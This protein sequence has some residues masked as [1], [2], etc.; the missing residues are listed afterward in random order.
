MTKKTIKYMAGLLAMALW[1]TPATAQQQAEKAK[2]EVE[3]ARISFIQMTNLRPLGDEFDSVDYIMWSKDGKSLLVDRRYADKRTDALEINVDTQAIK[4][5]S[6]GRPNGLRCNNGAPAWNPTENGYIFVG[7]SESSKDFSRSIPSNGQQC[8]LWYYNAGTGKYTALTSYQLSFTSPRGV[9]MPRFSPDGKKVFFEPYSVL[10]R[11]EDSF[12]DMIRDYLHMVMHCIFRHPYDE[13]HRDHRSWWLACDV[14]AESVAME[15]CGG[16]FDCEDDKA[17]KAALSELRLLC[18][19]IMPGKLYSLFEKTYKAPYGKSHMGLT[20]EKLNEY[21]SLFERVLSWH[22]VEICVDIARND[23]RYL[24]D[25]LLDFGYINEDNLE[26]I[27]TAV[28]KLQDAAMTGYLLE[29]KRLRFNRSAFDF[30][31]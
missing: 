27:I 21:A 15:M 16:R 2:G 4:N 12:N 3:D 5:L 11:F 23:D 18:G 28:N 7:Q 31:L 9:A 22:I 29:A 6:S 8:N 17:R 30:D 20:V 1:M 25:R 24:I 14:V 19:N 10:N 26:E 13:I